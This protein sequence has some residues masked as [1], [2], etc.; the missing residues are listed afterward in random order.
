MAAASVAA[1][2]VDQ[3]RPPPDELM[4]IEPEALDI[5]IPVPELRLAA[6]GSLAVVPIS[7]WPA[8]STIGVKA[9]E[10]SAIRI[11]CAVGDA[12]PDPPFAEDNGKG[13]SIILFVVM[14]LNPFN[15]KAG[16]DCC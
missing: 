16:L 8:E 3:E 12:T 13:L 9:L 15:V 5:E 1:V 4:V 2:I 6:D 7:T 14:T 10:P 11:P